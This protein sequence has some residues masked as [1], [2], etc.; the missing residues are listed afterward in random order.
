MSQEIS[1]LLYIKAI[2]PVPEA[3]HQTG[4]FPRSQELWGLEGHTQLKTPKPLG[5]LP[6]IQDAFPSINPLSS[7]ARGSASVSRPEKSLPA[8]PDTPRAP[9]V[10]EV[11]I[12]GPTLPVPG[13]AV[14][15]VISP[16]DFYQVGGGGDC[17]A[18]TPTF[19]STLLS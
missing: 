8:C 4:F 17:H 9:K 14:W 13:N 18:Q 16:L 19:S 3:Q 5:T 15:P 11:R 6:Q 1:H 12:W 7:E 10:P 2:E